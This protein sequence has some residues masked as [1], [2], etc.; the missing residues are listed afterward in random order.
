MPDPIQIIGAA[1]IKSL[2]LEAEALQALDEEW[3]RVTVADLMDEPEAA[4]VSFREA[5]LARIV[6]PLADVIHVEARAQVELKGG[7]T[8]TREA[9]KAAARPSDTAWEVFGTATQREG[10]T[11]LAVLAEDQTMA[12][13]MGLSD[14][15]LA[16][17]LILDREQNG[18]IFGAFRKAWREQIRALFRRVANLVS[19]AAAERVA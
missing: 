18:P 9:A 4:L 10:D 2:E 16:E 7:P 1:K 12:H 5:M 13:A 17:R 19:V 15:S 8:T 11:L 3:A 14:E 6:D